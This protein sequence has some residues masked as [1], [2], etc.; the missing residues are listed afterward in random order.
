MTAAEPAASAPRGERVAVVIPAHDEAATIGPIVAAARAYG[1]V[2]VCDD[3][4][5]D[6][7]AAAARAAGARVLRHPFCLGKGTA[8]ATAMSW[9]L[10]EGAD[11]VITLDAD[12][13]HRPEDIPRFL[14]AARK[15][16]HH[17]VIG[18]RCHG[19]EAQPRAR[20]LANR[21]ADFW[22]SWAAAHPVADSQCGFRCYPRPV[23]EHLAPLWRW[24]RGFAFET[25]LLIAAARAGFRTVALDIAAIYGGSG[26]RASHFRPVRDVAR[27]V[28]VVALFLLSRGLAPRAL[29]RALTLP[30]ECFECDPS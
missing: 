1:T 17:I 15:H 16:P 11:F 9:A 13:Q 26:Q 14:A 27:I 3:G 8:L 12:G 6:A 7:T 5:R 30:M 10:G 20:R 22:I 23:L 25:A 4:S 18:W 2:I 28:L 24:P 29:W 21:F 19:R